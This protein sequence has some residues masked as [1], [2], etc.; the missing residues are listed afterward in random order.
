MALCRQ[1]N[2]YTRVP[3]IV[4]FVAVCD[5]LERGMADSERVDRR[6]EQLAD[7]C[8]GLACID[9]LA[10]RKRLLVTI[11]WCAGCC[12]LRQGRCF[13]GSCMGQPTPPDGPTKSLSSIIVI[14]PLVQLKCEF[15]TSISPRLQDDITVICSCCR[16]MPHDGAAFDTTAATRRASPAASLIVSAYTAIYAV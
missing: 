9:A 16:H 4:V 12:C 3:R 1:R 11:S 7:C 6:P 14:S 5:M 8:Y 15:N 10:R 13:L 2:V